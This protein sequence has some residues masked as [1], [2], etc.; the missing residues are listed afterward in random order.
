[1]RQ[2]WIEGAL[3]TAQ[4]AFFKITKKHVGGNLLKDKLKLT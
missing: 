4:E 1:M 3:E 2:A